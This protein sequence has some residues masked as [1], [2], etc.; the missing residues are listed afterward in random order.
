[1]A[2]R[3]CSRCNG[4]FEPE[5][6]K[7]T[8]RCPECSTQH[9]RDRWQ[10]RMADPLERDL[11]NLRRSSRWQVARRRCFMRDGYRCRGVVH[12]EP[13]NSTE[14]LEA[15][16]LVLARDLLADGRDACDLRYLATLCVSCHGLADAQLRS[17]PS[18]S[19]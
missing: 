15:H 14:N 4:R 13:C 18:S 5:T 6:S 3:V 2:H 8:P 12:G 19:S 10:E 11:R 9:H 16:H 17:R 1:M 7:N